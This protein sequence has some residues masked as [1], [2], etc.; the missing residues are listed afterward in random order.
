MRIAGIIAEFNPLHKGHAHLIRSAK[1]NG[2]DAVVVIMSGSFVQRGEPAFFDK[3]SRT[4][5]ALSAGADLVLELPCAYAT[6]SAAQ[7][8]SGAVKSLLAS[9]EVNEL[10]FGAETA[11][12]E[13]LERAAKGLRSSLFSEKIAMHLQQ[14]IS[15]AAAQQCA[16]AEIDPQAAS[17]LSH[18]NN[19]LAIQYITE[20]IRSGAAMKIHAVPRIGPEHD[21]VYSEDMIAGASFLRKLIFSEGM[22]AASSYLP[23]GVYSIFAEEVKKGYAPCLASALERSILMKLRGM[24]VEELAALPDVSEG[25]ENRLFQAIKS[26]CNVEE[27]YSNVK[28]K[29]YAHARIR[30]I[31]LS[32]LLE[33]TSQ[34]RETPPPYLHVLG[35]SE[36][37]REVFRAMRESASVPVLTSLASLAR[38]STEAARFAALETHATDIF[39][40]ASPVVRPCGLDFD[41]P[42]IKR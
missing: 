18:P 17:L 10:W 4:A 24:S 34:D 36:A 40:L 42:P 29:R 25:L 39:S 14:G 3:F 41:T 31:I 1:E 33:I 20:I 12:T 8:A 16:L 21:A 5:A 13:L 32:A 15:Y 11:D 38:Y 23:E 7:F 27:L 28:S 30:R 37:G 6:A 35:F 22:Q 2:C 26:S 19:A 9:S